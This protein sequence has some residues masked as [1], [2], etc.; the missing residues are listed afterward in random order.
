MITEIEAKTLLRKHGRV[1][2]W[3]VSVAGMNVYRGCAHDCVYCDGRAEKYRVEGAFGEDIAWKR[4]AADV[5]RRELDPAR[6]RVPLKRGYLLLGGGVGDSYQPVEAQTG[7][8]R[9]LL[10]VIEASGRPVHILTKSALVERDFDILTRIH[11]QTRAMVSVSLSTVDD[12]LGRFLEPGAALPSRRLETVA[13]AKAAGLYAGVY[14]MPVIPGLS[15]SPEALTESLR[16][17]KQAGADFVIFGGLTMKV[18]RQKD[19]FLREVNRFAPELTPRLDSLY[20]DPQWGN[21]KGDYAVR[22][23]LRFGHL[24][25]EAGIP[26]RIPPALYSDLVDENNRVAIMLEHVDYLMQMEGEVSAHQWAARAI[27]QMDQPVSSRLGSLRGIR[28]FGPATEKLI[29]EILQ[30]GSLKRLETLL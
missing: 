4:N 7:I 6:K 30:S 22:L 5:L 20:K 16:Q 26:R 15:D 27:A 14:L 28:G 23:N 9:E 3:F 17:I 18:G 13:H 25:K 8:T 19:Y 12:R 24:A 21:A 1:D 29:A 2:A 10:E 11:A